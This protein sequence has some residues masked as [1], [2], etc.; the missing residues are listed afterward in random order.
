MC[1]GSKISTNR[2]SVLHEKRDRL[3]IDNESSIERKNIVHYE[4]NK[5][6]HNCKTEA[7]DAKVMNVIIH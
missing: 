7:M 6:Q 2:H 3:E 1:K 5:D 4:S